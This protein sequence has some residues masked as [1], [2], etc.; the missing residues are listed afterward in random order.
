MLLLGFN[1]R[2]VASVGVNLL[3]LVLKGVI[4][5]RTKPRV[6]PIDRRGRRGA[7]SD[8]CEDVLSPIKGLAFYPPGGKQ[9]RTHGFSSSPHF[10]A[11]LRSK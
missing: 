10:A 2:A 5:R 6:V 11:P 4:L 7:G 8:R 1:G 3:D 9:Q